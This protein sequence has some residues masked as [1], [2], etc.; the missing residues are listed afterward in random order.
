[1][2]PPDS[3]FALAA[4]WLTFASAAAI[5]FS[6]AFSQILLALAFAALLA[7][8]DKLRLPRIKWPLAFFILGTLISLAFSGDP[9]AGLPQVRKFYVF[10]ELLV[11]YS[12]LRD[13]KVI[14]WLFFTWAGIGALTALRGFV[15]F[16]N[17]MQAAGELGRSSYDYYVG[18]RITGFT[19]HWNTYSAEEM[20]ALIMLGAFL[21]F[22]PR[23]ARRTW[24]WLACGGL[25]ALAVLLAWTRGVWIATAVAAVYLLWFWKRW[26]VALVPVAILLAYVAS[27][28]PIRTRFTSIFR[29]ASVDSNE[30]RVI[31]WR[32][33]IA[34][35]E[36]HPLLGLGPEGVNRHFKEYV[37]PDIG[38]LPAGWYGHLHNI[39]LHY[40]AERGIPTMLVLVWLLVQMVVDFWRGLR[41]LPPGPDM[42]KFLLHGGV[43]VVLAIM[44]EGVVELNLGDSEVLTMFLVVAGCG[45]LALEKDVTVADSALACHPAGSPRP[46]L[47]G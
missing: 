23:P 17:K 13:F 9:S 43:A 3:T 14:R 22:A 32:T 4:R 38:K 30:F 26:L 40:A 42:R 24:I 19:S 37:P 6:I 29:P 1:M 21:L 5:M 18:E 46:A 41:A 16:A 47:K 31:T 33:G 39:Y 36:K 25:M 10:L 27:P 2:K 20:I 11:V 44:V 28:A 8:G 15:Q 35:I 7:S 12:A 45:Y 34:M